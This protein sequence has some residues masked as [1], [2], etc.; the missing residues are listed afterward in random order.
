[1]NEPHDPSL[2]EPSQSTMAELVRRASAVRVPDAASAAVR[3]AD[4]PNAGPQPSE[5]WRVRPAGGDEATLAWVRSVAPTGVTVVPVSFDTDWAGESTL[6]VPP[7]SSPLGLPLAVHTEVDLVMDPTG[8]LDRLGVLDPDATT[9]WPTGSRIVSALDQR[10]EYRATLTDTI[11]GLRA[12]ARLEPA[13]TDDEWWPQNLHSDIAGLLIDLHD[14]LSVSHP[15]ARISPTALVGSASEHV[16]AVVH[17]SE[18]DAFVL[19]GFRDVEMD[20]SSL[21]E[22]ARQ[23]L[24]ADQLLNAVCLVQPASPF[25]AVVI[26]RRDV[27]A[28]IETPSG[29]LRPPRPSFRPAPVA[30]ALTKFLDTAITPFGR[31]AGAVVDAEAVDARGLAVDVAADATRAT[32]ASARGFKVEGKR[33]GYE[34]VTKHQAAITRLVEQALNDVDVDVASI[35]GTDGT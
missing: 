26:D 24:Q 18:L 4:R 20:D 27:V 31:L 10:G 32:A 6:I 8:F 29:A 14:G 35:L 21:L 17:V 15:G 11:A 33:P 22:A 9:E 3:E 19:V 28:A 5:L 2:D 23:L 12:E 13:A 7:D 16:R 34:R 30:E 1:M 25:V